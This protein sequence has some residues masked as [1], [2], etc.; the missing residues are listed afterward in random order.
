MLLYMGV[1]HVDA[2]NLFSAVPSSRT[3]V[4]G[5]KLEHRMF[6]MDMWKS[7]FT[8]R[9]TEHWNRLPRNVVEFPSLQ[10][11][12]T[13]LNSFLCNLLSGTYFSTRLYSVISTDPFQHL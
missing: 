6:R 7:L 3:K 9:L 4:N 1:S 8:L 2:A 13:H 10:T 11:L 5:L 12:K